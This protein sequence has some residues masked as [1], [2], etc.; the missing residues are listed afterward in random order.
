MLHS[1]LKCRCLQLYVEALSDKVRFFFP[2]KA[3][4]RNDLTCAAIA[5]V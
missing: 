3:R 2:L 1:Y 5:K 4:N